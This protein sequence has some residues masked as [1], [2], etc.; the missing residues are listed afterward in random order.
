[1]ARLYSILVN[2][3]C[4]RT[5]R[6][7]NAASIPN[8]SYDMWVWKGP[9]YSLRTINY[10]ISRLEAG[11]DTAFVADQSLRQFR[12]EL[13]ERVPLSA[14][15]RDPQRKVWAATP[16]VSYRLLELN[17]SFSVRDDQFDAVLEL[18]DRHDLW[19]YDP[20]RALVQA[21]LSQRNDP[22]RRSI[23][24]RLLAAAGRRS[25]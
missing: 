10:G 11:D 21:P 15:G 19:L 18:V 9:P 17:L 14:D 8:V 5:P 24:R 4:P 12:N 25:S 20:Q 13:L 6:R 16:N 2:R 23:W 3:G 22:P 7:P 1:M